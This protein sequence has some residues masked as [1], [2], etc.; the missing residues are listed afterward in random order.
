M[1]L[2]LGL[3]FAGCFVFA[4]GAFAEQ[5]NGYISDAHCGTMHSS[6]SAANTKCIKACLKKGTAP[7]VV[8]NGKVMQIA[9]ASQK[10]AAAHAGQDVSINGTVNDNT[11]TIDSIKKAK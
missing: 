9:E 6:P 3:L 11:I 7:V 2:T 5:I 10:E 8:S 1:K 4:S